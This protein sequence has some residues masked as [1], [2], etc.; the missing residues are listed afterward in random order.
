VA[1]GRHQ[2][3]AFEQGFQIVGTFGQARFDIT[4]RRFERVAPFLSL[5]G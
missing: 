1:E 4:Q 2:R 3:A 5:V